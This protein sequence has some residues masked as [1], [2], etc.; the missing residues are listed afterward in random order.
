[1]LAQSFTLGATQILIGATVNLSVTL[2][3]AG[4]ARWFSRNPVWLS[5]QRY[6]MGLVLGAL[7]VRLLLE[8]RR[9]V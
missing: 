6:V 2:G 5:V 9:A 8:Q 1:V 7:A 3:A 4:I